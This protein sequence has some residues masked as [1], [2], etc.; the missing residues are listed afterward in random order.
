MRSD[1]ALQLINEP[2]LECHSRFGAVDLVS[3]AHVVWVCVSVRYSS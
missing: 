2:H 1:F 3:I